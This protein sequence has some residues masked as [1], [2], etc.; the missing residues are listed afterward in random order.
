M[1]SKLGEHVPFDRGVNTGGS[2]EHWL[3]QLEKTMTTNMRFQ[4]FFSYE[5]MDQ[6]LIPIPEE[7]RDFGKFM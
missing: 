7:K 6:D 3:Q 5:D 1:V 2:P 4:V